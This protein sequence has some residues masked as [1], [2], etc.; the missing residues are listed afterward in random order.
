MCIY[1]NA[2]LRGWRGVRDA[3]GRRAQRAAI[4]LLVTVIHATERELGT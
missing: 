3:A 2:S 1:E 4:V